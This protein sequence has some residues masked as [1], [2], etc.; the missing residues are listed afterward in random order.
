[1][2]FSD[3]NARDAAEKGAW[4]HLRNPV[5]GAPLL[6]GDDPCRV[7]VRGTE[8]RSVQSGFAKMVK[9]TVPE[10]A[11]MLTMAVE[12]VEVNGE[13]ITPE[14]SHLLYGLQVPNGQS[15]EQSFAEQVVGFA[16]KRANYLPNA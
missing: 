9:L 13:P 3:F 15:G 11:K 8:S 2:E 7:M 4:L 16:L 1:M 6:D 10:Q 12:F 14:N 5:N